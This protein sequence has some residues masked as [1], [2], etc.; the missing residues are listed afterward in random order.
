[1]FEFGVVLDEFVVL[2]DFLDDEEDGVFVL[3]QVFELVNL[4]EVGE[5]LAVERHALVGQFV[6]RPV[7]LDDLVHY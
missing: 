1:M 7:L 2:E 4:G 5:E 3:D 6:V